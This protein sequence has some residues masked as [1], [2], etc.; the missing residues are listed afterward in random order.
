ME[1]VLDFWYLGRLL[2]ASDDDWTAV[3]GSIKKV[4]RIWGRLDQVIG[5]EGGGT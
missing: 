2:T 5:M 1:A 4:R 3:T